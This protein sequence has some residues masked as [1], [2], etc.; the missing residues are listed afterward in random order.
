MSSS[1]KESVK[2]K[3]EKQEP[4]SEQQPVKEDLELVKPQNEP[5]GQE[6]KKASSIRKP[7]H[8]R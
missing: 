8:T 3:I 5:I 6:R 1:A 4:D 7:R 2:V